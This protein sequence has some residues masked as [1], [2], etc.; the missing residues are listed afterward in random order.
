M[1]GCR[2]GEP[3][4]RHAASGQWPRVGRAGLW[5]GLLKALGWGHVLMCSHVA[6]CHLVLSEDIA[7][8]Q[9]AGPAHVNLARH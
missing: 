1:G 3:R 2:A 4:G 7:V 6:S 8:V 9:L 5:Q